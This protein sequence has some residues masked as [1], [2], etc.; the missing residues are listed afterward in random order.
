MRYFDAGF[1][2][3]LTAARVDGIAPVYFAHFTA[4]DRDTRAARTISLWTGDDDIAVTVAQPGGGLVSRTYIGGCGFSI[5]NGIPYVGDLTDNPVTISISQI[6]DSA[7][8]LVRGYD[9]RLAPCEIHATSWAGGV[10][11]SAP[12][13][14]W[15]GVVDDGPISTPAAGSDGGIS[16]TIR[17]EIMWMLGATNPTK[18]SDEHQKRRASGDR[19]AEYSGIIGERKVTWRKD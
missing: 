9:L 19:F 10:F 12:Q 15:V 8:Q 2:A 18:S 4:R 3:S 16:L 1:T 7:Q 14:Q 6:A 11:A 17:S 13:L 5:P